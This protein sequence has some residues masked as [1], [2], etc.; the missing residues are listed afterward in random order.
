MVKCFLIVSEY[1]GGPMPGIL[2]LR[3]CVDQMGDAIHRLGQERAWESIL[4]DI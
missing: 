4:L 1:R 2:R 3:V